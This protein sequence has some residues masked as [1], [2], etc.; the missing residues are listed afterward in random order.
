MTARGVQFYRKSSIE[1]EQASVEKVTRNQ[2][3]HPPWY[4]LTHSYNKV[5][6]VAISYT[7]LYQ[8]DQTDM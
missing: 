7:D 3:V 5:I 4:Y 8:S 6:I 2:G 1:Y